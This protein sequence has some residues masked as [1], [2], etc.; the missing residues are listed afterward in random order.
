[1]SS[2]ATILL[3]GMG[4]MSL[5]SLV[6]SSGLVT[7]VNEDLL[8]VDYLDFLLIG[9]WGKPMVNQGTPDTQTDPNKPIY[10][11]TSSTEHCIDKAFIE[12]DT[13][14][15]Q[16][17]N[18]PDNINSCLSKSRIDCLAGGG[19]WTSV[20]GTKDCNRTV[21][22]TCMLD[23]GTPKYQACIDQNKSACM[24]NGGVWVST[25]MSSDGTVMYKS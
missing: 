7:L 3:L 24:A 13:V 14:L 16:T 12:C 4:S 17:P 23:K 11:D 15:K 25:T 9:G 22:K 2:A 10:N 5:L 19:S 20:D 18:S 8:D 6:F 21:T 1:M